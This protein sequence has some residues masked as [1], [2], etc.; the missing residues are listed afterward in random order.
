MGTVQQNEPCLIEFIF[1]FKFIF[2]FQVGIGE[3]KYEHLFRS[4]VWRIPRL[5]DKQSAAYKSYMLKCRFTLTS[6]DL[7]PETF[8]PQS[9]LEFTMPLAVVSNTVVRSIGVEQHEDSDRVE[10]FVR[11]LAKF[12]YR[13]DNDYIQCSDLDMEEGKA[14]T[15]QSTSEEQHY[16]NVEAI[17]EPYGGYRIELPDDNIQESQI[18]SISSK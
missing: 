6:F 5:P 1:V 9:E 18:P 11:Y 15:K 7:M 3:A 16:E 17:N 13:I 14:E 10:K 8:I 12:H 4:L 2:V